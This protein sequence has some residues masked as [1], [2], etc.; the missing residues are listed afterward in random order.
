M[1]MRLHI[2]KCVLCLHSHAPQPHTRIFFYAGTRKYMYV[3]IMQAHAI[4]ALVVV[5]L[6]WLLYYDFSQSKALGGRQ[7]APGKFGA[8]AGAEGLRG[9]YQDQMPHKTALIGQNA[10]YTKYTQK[11]HDKI[12]VIMHHIDW[13]GACKRIMPIWRQIKLDVTNKAEYSGIIMLENDEGKS[14]TAGIRQYPTIVKYAKGRTEVY[15][16]PLN[17]ISLQR[18]VLRAKHYNF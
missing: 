2:Y 16:G 3:Y 10:Y 8:G 12:I 13:C 1:S 9:H 15:S 6:L 11:N 7:K 18:F 14:P 5:L 17:E 4:F